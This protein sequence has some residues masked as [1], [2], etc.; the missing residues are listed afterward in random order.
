[1]RTVTEKIPDTLRLPLTATI[2]ITDE[3]DAVIVDALYEDVPTEVVVALFRRGF[4]AYCRR[5]ELNG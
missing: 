1:M 4:K 3:G 5:N 2:H